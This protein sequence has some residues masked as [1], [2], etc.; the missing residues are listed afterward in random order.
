YGAAMASAGE[1]EAGTHKRL[2]YL[3][4][5]ADGR[6]VTDLAAASRVADTGHA[7]EAFRHPLIDTDDLAQVGPGVLDYFKPLAREL[8]EP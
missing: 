5:I 8:L 7:V 6:F 2:S 4:S 3:A 1:N